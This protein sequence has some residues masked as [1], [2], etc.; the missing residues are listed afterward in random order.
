MELLCNFLI[1]IPIFNT[2]FA[3][4]LSNK[5]YLQ[6]S[7]LHLL[8]ELISLEE[9]LQFIYDDSEN[10][11]QL[12][13]ISNPYIITH[14]NQPIRKSL[15]LYDTY[16]IFTANHTSLDKTLNKL[17]QSN[18]WSTSNSPRGKFIVVASRYIDIKIL[19][20][21][22][23]KCDIV[24]FSLLKKIRYRKY[25]KSG[26]S[27]IS[28]FNNQDHAYLMCYTS[29]P[30]IEERAIK[31]IL[32]YPVNLSTTKAPEFKAI[33]GLGL[34]FLNII[35]SFFE[36]EVLQVLTN[37]TTTLMYSKGTGIY[38]ILSTTRDVKLYE[39]YDVCNYLFRDIMGWAVPAP[40]K[41]STFKT[42][43]NTL[44][45]KVWLAV[46]AILIAESILWWLF[47]K[48]L[49]TQA[50][51][52][53]FE[54]CTLSSFFITLGGSSQILPK[55]S[56]LRVLLLFYLFYSMQV[57]TVFQGKLFSGLTHPSLEHGITTTE[58]LTE[59]PL[60][61]I[62]SP[63]TKDFKSKYFDND[64]VF[65]KL[66]TKLIVQHPMNMTNNLINIAR[67]RNCSSLMGKAMLLYC[68]PGFKPLVH[69]IERNT[70]IIEFELN[71]AI[72]KGHYFLEVLNKFSRRVMESGINLKMF[73]DATAG[74]SNQAIETDTGASVLGM[75]H[76]DGLFIFWAIGLL[77]A[78]LVFVAEMYFYYC[79]HNKGIVY[80][81]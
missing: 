32:P 18:L 80:Y 13:N 45:V 30:T 48:S 41:V 78:I 1:I 23:H 24:R 64:T 43:A 72:R 77:S 44:D 71:L 61:I 73:S 81:V 75:H 69:L 27:I 70:G 8:Q 14:I 10:Y 25:N 17:Q 21:I 62:G 7:L 37:D 38:V 54:T 2:I 47:S 39:S 11:P 29:I 35:G 68:F 6:E 74:Y 34:H 12:V 56:S 46:I 51:L 26:K 63:K 53:D 57:S 16:V 19:T 5:N 9:T 76:V 22:F 52:V 60:A 66:L 55:T 4:K 67:F 65:T 36:M 28:N 40:E 33:F 42:I 49:K 15:K 3:V 58:E 79:F 20:D 59:S 50:K 31:M